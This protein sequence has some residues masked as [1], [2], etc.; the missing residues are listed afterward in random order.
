MICTEVA[1]MYEFVKKVIAP[2]GAAAILA[3][4]FYPLCVE[5][6]QCDYL[7]LWIF[8]GIPFGVHKMFLWIIPKGFDIGGTVGMFIFNLLIGGV[9]GGFVLA[10]RLLMAAFYLVKMVFAGISRLMRAKAVGNFTEE[11]VDERVT[12]A[13]KSIYL[14]AFFCLYG[15]GTLRHGVAK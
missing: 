10:W 2:V 13:A 8:M 14:A 3:A 7:K 6:G 9:I 1:E 11:Q 5:N 12:K 15:R 4:L